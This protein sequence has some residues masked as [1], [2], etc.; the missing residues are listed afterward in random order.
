MPIT[1]EAKLRYLENARIKRKNRTLEELKKESDYSKA[2]YRSMSP[3]K[4]REYIDKISK[5][6]KEKLKNETLEERDKRRKE[7]REYRKA[8]A[9]KR[10]YED[11]SD[12][13]I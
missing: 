10:I 7:M 12:K 1:P 8:M 3:E 4:K 5:R 9:I 13:N 6:N 2:K 11:N